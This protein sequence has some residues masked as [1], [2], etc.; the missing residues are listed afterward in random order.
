MNK[1]LKEDGGHACVHDT[2]PCPKK[3]GDMY[4]WNGSSVSERVTGETP[5][6]LKDVCYH[7]KYKD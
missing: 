1:Q 5:T 7:L 6:R 2:L 3:R 4:I